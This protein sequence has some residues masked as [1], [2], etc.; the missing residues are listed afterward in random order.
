MRNYLKR[1]T[2]YFFI[3][4]L[5]L[6]GCRHGFHKPKTADKYAF[7]KGIFYY[8]PELAKEPKYERCR[9]DLYYPENAKDFTTVIWFHAGGLKRGNRY[10]PGALRSKG[11]AVAAVSY[12]LYPDAKAPEFLEDAAAAIAWVF[13]NIEKFGGDKNKIIVAGASA[14]AYLSAMA[15]LDKKWLAK[16]KIDANKVAGV[17]LLSGQMITHVAVRQEKGINRKTP[18]INQY[19]PLSFVRSDAPPILL[20]TGDR[21]LELLGRYEENAY[22]RRMML[23][24]GYPEFPLHEIKGKNHGQVE[25]AAYPLLLEFIEKIRKNSNK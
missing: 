4:L 2:F 8:S 20:V 9:L 1:F 3:L 25:R 5:P 7:K 21:E 6:S 11:L 10:I 16:H 19:A 23:I 15:I 13:Q 18:L 24:S 22:F 12:R 17:A 14:G